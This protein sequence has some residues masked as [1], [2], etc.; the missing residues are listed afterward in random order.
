MIGQTAVMEYMILVLMT[1]FIIFFALIMIF[2]FQFLTIGSETSIEVEERSLFVLQ[3][4]ISSN[5]VG[6]PHFL[7][8]SVL[9]DSKLTVVD[10]GKI[11][12]MFGADVFVEV[13]AFYDK[14]N[15]EGL[16]SW[17]Y[18]ECLEAVRQITESENK[19]CT[20]ENYPDCG[21]WVFCEKSEKMVYRAVPVN[22]YRTMNNTFSLGTVTV[23][24]GA[25]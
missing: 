9:D 24:V 5:I 15:C 6:N 7:K 1:M 21:C 4:F 14:P 18:E 17:E 25:S 11:E 13:R 16:S 19:P 3:S 2:G 20:P 10:C 23:G 12:E 22:V 8:G